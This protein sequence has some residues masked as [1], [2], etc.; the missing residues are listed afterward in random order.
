MMLSPVP[1]SRVVVDDGFWAP[2]L[3]TNRLATIPMIYERC[4]ESGRIDAF[5][6]GWKEGDPN[7]P[8]VF[9][10]SDL[11]K[12]ME[13]AA[14]SLRTHPDPQLERQ[15]EDV[16]KRLIRAQQPDGYLNA[17]YT[18]VEPGKRW[19]NLRDKHEL[20]CAGHLIE[21]AVAHFETTG[22]RNFLDAMCHFADHI[23]AQFGPQPGKRRG[24]CGHPEIELALV[25]LFRVTR[26]ERYLKLATYFVNERGSKPH[27][28][29]TEAIARG[30]DPKTYWAK[31]HEYTQSHAP[32]REQSRAVGHA[33][34]ALY[35]YS[36][37]TDVA[38]ETGDKTLLEACSRLW[39]SV[40]RRQMYITGG[41]GPSREN[42]G[43]TYDYDLPNDTAYAETCASI[44]SVFW[45]HRLLQWHCESRFGDEI[46]RALYNAILSGVSMDGTAFFYVNPLEM[47]AEEIK[48]DDPYLK[49]HRVPW[50][51]C[52]CCPPNIA[53]LLAS[54]GQYIYSEADR[55]VAIHLYVQSHAD[56]TVA[57]RPVR[58]RQEAEYPWKGRVRIRVEAQSPVEFCLRL[59]IPGWARSYELLLNGKTISAELEHGYA[60]LRRRWERDDILE[61]ILPMRIERVHAHPSVRNNFGRVALQRGPVV[62]CV[63]SIDVGIPVSSLVIPK[64]Q[65]FL[66]VYEKQM[67][68]GTT[69]IRGE[70]AHVADSQ[71]G[72]QLYGF[73]NPSMQSTPFK[74]VPYAVWGNRDATEMA[75]WLRE[76]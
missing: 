21:A 63:E 61:L 24:Y 51:G 76:A 8:H 25:R 13:A 46:E 48:P 40:Y 56:C 68:A 44:A 65:E 58:I 5:R 2:R 53:R 4:K 41:I 30:E 12:W 33:V 57:G 73:G 55:D 66:A 38:R 52:A 1:I 49:A 7:K 54:L 15:L 11:A 42:E 3:E 14:C 67:F 23:D 47:H 19:T 28:F 32:V 69:T 17:Y 72:R 75:V 64:G 18:V 16:I 34:R 45:N 9:W 20:Y 31:T 70:A 74:A 10:E 22:R 36:G 62:Y 37:M 60:T 26:E 6:L 29:D 43:F 27:Y 35:L 50:F 71:W 39:E 59:R